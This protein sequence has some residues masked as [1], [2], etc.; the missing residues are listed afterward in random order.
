MLWD[1]SKGMV[2]PLMGSFF[3]YFVIGA[4]RI[5]RVDGAHGHGDVRGH[6]L[7]PGDPEEEEE[8]LSDDERDLPE[9]G[10]EA[11]GVSSDEVS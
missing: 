4:F 10:L 2:V 7:P 6:P 9:D 5:P 11:G 8:R 3:K 1:P